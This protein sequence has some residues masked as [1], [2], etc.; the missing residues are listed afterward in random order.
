M[1]LVNKANFVV[2]LDPYPEIVRELMYELD[3][4]FNNQSEIDFDTVVVFKM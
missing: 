3:E 2:D 4:I 1:E